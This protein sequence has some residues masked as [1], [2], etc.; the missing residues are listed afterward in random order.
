VDSRDFLLA[1]NDLPHAR[2]CVH[3]RFGGTRKKDNS[4][5]NDAAVDKWGLVLKLSPELFRQGPRPTGSR[6]LAHN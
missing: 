6:A 3:V 5:A 2:Y 4:R 1:D